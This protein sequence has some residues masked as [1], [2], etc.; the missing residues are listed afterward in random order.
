MKLLNST[1][2]HRKAIISYF[3]KKS[4]P[5]DQEPRHFWTTFR[6][7]LHSRKSQQANNVFLSENDRVVTDKQ[8]IANIFNKHFVNITT[9]DIKEPESNRGANFE[10]YPS[11][12]AI[13]A[14]IP[15]V[16]FYLT[17]L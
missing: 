13:L 8:S 5:Q 12:S 16:H 15:E 7:F 2:L 17:F 6:P 9:S 14:K 3:R 10:D 11:I 4:L 1:L